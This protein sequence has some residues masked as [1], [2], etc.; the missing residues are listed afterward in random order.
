MAYQLIMGYLMP[1]FSY[2]GSLDIFISKCIAGMFSLWKCIVCNFFYYENVF[3]NFQGVFTL[4]L[5]GSLF[6]GTLTDTT[7]RV[8]KG[9]PAI[10]W[11][12]H[13]LQNLPI[14][15]HDAGCSLSS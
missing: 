4:V 3:L 15:A 13:A 10:K 14:G 5:V 2:L 9:T 12:H 11:W 7:I 6:A 1:K 8:D